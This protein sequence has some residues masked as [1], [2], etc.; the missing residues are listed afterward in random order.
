MTMIRSFTPAP[1]REGEI[2]IHSLD[3]FSLHVPQ[4]SQAEDFYSAF[5]LD[6][7]PLGNQLALVAREIR[8][9]GGY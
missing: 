9:S 1:R 6:L 3:H 7:K 4:M 5:G 8:T 2:G